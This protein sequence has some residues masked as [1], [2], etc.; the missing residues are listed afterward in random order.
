MAAVPGSNIERCPE[1]PREAAS[2][3]SLSADRRP[4]LE[5]WLPRMLS[6]APQR[7]RASAA[8]FETVGDA[9]AEV[10]QRRKGPRRRRAGCGRAGEVVAD[11]PW[12]VNP[13]RSGPGASRASTMACAAATPTVFTAASPNRIALPPAVSSVENGA[14]EPLTSG[15]KRAI[16]W[17]AL[18]D[19]QWV[20]VVAFVVFLLRG[21]IGRHELRRV[22]GLEPG[23]LVGDE[24]VAG[25]VGLVKAVAG[26]WLNKLPDL[27]GL[28]LRHL[29]F[30]TVRNET[31]DELLALLFHLGLNLLPHRL[32]QAICRRP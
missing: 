5:P 11:Q 10:R 31:G 29:E 22:M 4:L 12:G 32:A 9:L 6:S 17:R 21:E 15:G 2:H 7:I 18:A 1:L 3:S 30:T 14:C 13:G 23:G 25:R 20:I 27:L 24:P 16:R 19:G 26:E 8:F 28:P